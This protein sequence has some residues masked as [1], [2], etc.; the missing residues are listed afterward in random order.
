MLS[1]DYC[2]LSAR[3]KEEDRDPSR[4][5]E[6]PVLVLHDSATKN[7]FAHL[8][9]RKGVDYAGVEAVAINF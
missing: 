5:C 8:V 2:Y 4:N 3:T 1:W 9:P 6:N 7:I